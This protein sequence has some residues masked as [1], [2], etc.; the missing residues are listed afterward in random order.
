MATQ[1][2]ENWAG[3]LYANPLE[4]LKPTSVADLQNIVNQNQGKIIRAAGTQAIR[5]VPL[6]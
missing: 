4:Y 2:W 3:S 6:F 1:T 5:G